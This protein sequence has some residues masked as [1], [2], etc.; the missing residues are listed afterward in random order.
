[1]ERSLSSKDWVVIQRMLLSGCP[2]YVTAKSWVVADGKTGEIF[3]GHDELERR[4]IASLTKIMTAY[5]A[6]T[7]A[8]Q[9]HLD[10][11]EAKLL[12]SEK[13]AF[14][15]G[16]KAFIEEGDRLSLHDM[17]HGMMLPSGN[18]AALAIA[19][20]FGKLIK[21]SMLP[22]IPLQKLE[23]VKMPSPLKLFVQR[24]NKNAQEMG[25]TET[26]YANPHG[27]TNFNNKSSA[28][29]IAKLAS[30]AMH[31]PYFSSLVRCR[32][33]VCKGLNSKGE[34]KLFKWKNTN[35][36]LTKGYSGVKTGITQTAGPCLATS[37]EKEGVSLIVVVLNTKTVD[38]RWVEVKKLTKWAILRIKKIEEMLVG[39]SIT[40]KKKLLQ[41][42]IHV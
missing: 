22:P 18:D 10:P 6:I 40:E 30:V 33:Y 21:D 37:I 2:P 20:Y 7:L 15:T 9:F 5:T 1:M 28:K 16:T 23:P 8:K 14:M 35:K 41:M 26:Y 24:M 39:E 27:L 19:E 29:D 25:L 36:L 32:R 13:A 3:F 11:C 31:D 17:F 4:E 38:Q 12:V 34:E 42:L